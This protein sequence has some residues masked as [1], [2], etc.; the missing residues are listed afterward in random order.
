[1]IKLLSIYLLMQ[2]ALIEARFIRVDNPERYGVLLESY[3]GE[4]AL[5]EPLETIIE[6]AK[7]WMDSLGSDVE[8]TPEMEQ[9]HLTFLNIG[10][11][12][13]GKICG[14]R[15]VQIASSLNGLRKYIGRAHAIELRPDS[16]PKLRKLIGQA[17]DSYERACHPENIEL[18]RK[19][20]EKVPVASQAIVRVI[21]LKYRETS[22]KKSTQMSAGFTLA[23]SFYYYVIQR[24]GRADSD[25]RCAT[26]ADSEALNAFEV[27]ESKMIEIY[28]RC[29]YQ[30]CLDYYGALRSVVPLFKN[31]E[32]Y[33]DWSDRDEK[34]MKQ[35][36]ARYRTC[37]M[38]AGSN[39]KIYYEEFKDFIG[40]QKEIIRDR[41]NLIMSIF[42]KSKPVPRF[43]S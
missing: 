8:V 5:N 18:L 35:A 13:E 2:V 40:G 12:A 21:D 16:Y 6:K 24:V 15:G 37:S 25:E 31:F 22:F 26:S 11:L 38:V 10:Q 29:M 4:E 30:P 3:I 7:G 20:L 1:M 41:P 36:L 27:S 28:D 19:S 43:V 14:A 39:A 33:T 32:L 17:I 9:L 42:Q 34:E 23:K